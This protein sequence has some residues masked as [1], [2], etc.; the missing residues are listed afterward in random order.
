M[1]KRFKLL[2]LALIGVRKNYEVNFKDGLNYISGPTSTGKTSILE[3]INYSLG[4]SSHKDYIEIGQSCKSVELEVMV[5]DEKFKIIRKLF[6]FNEP[7][8]IFTWNEKVNTYEF[9]DKLDVDSP[10]NEKS[11]SAFLLEKLDLSNIKVANQAFSFRDVYKF[12]YLRQTEIDNE[13][14]M[15]EKHWATSIK[16]KPTFEIIFNIYDELL[17]ELKTSLRMKQE[18]LRDLQIKLDGI[19]EFLASTEIIN[20]ETYLEKKELINNTIHEKQKQLHEIKSKGKTDDKLTLSLQN[21]IVS[22][23]SDIQKIEKSIS[24]QNEYLNKLTLLRN[25]YISEKDKIDF[26]IDGYHALEKFDFINCPS[27]LQPIE[28]DKPQL[29]GLCGKEKANADIDEVMELKLQKQRLAKKLKEL[30]S[31]NITEV[32]NLET[33]IKQSDNYK[34]DLYSLEKEL[35]H[36]HKNYINP[37]IEQMEQLN[38]EIGEDNRILRELDNN[39]KILLELERFKKLI[40]IKDKAI[41]DLRQR[42]NQTENISINKELLIESLSKQFNDI[43]K[44]FKFPKLENAYIDGKTYLPYVRERLYRELG[45]LAGVTLITMAYYLAIAVE[46]RSEK[47]NHLGFIVI[48]SPRKNLGAKADDELFKDE[49]IFNS[50]IKFFIS[51]DEKYQND[52]QLI[53]VNNGYPTFLDRKHVIKEFDGDGTKDLP[54][55]LIDDIQYS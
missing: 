18:E 26:I 22:L 53:V 49:D 2:K 29:C 12:S 54:Y 45:S 25:Q 15:G 46:A 24:D 52:I 39:Y 3:M 20:F 37:F 44:A 5:N 17:A 19:H 36:L 27:C 32:A 47:Y 9:L 21:K 8:A 38:Y 33:L 30:K 41:S 11:L 1:S 6:Q 42:I 50:I 40:D 4:A 10:S 28:N 31:F 23:K 16:R 48:D 14:I 51:M 13:N 34:T 7:V 55:G 35:L 43:L